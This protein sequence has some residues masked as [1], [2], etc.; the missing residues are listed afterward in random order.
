[1]TPQQLAIAYVETI[2]GPANGWGQYVHPTLG[3]SHA[4]MH[5]LSQIVGHDECQRLITEAMK[6]E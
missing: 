4:I 6:P 2:N 1:M 5:K 3:Q